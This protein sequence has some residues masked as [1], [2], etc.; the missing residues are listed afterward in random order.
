MSL[1]DARTLCPKLVVV[2]PN[3]PRYLHFS[4]MLR[5]IYSDYTDTVEPFGLDECWL[6]VTG[7]GLLFGSPEKIAHDIRRRVRFELGITVSVGVSWNKI[8]AKLGS[9]YKKPNAVTVI[10]KDNYKKIVYPLPVS[11]LAAFLG[12]MGYILHA[13]ANGRESSPVTASGCAPIIK[14]VGNG[15]TAPRDLKNE[16]DIKSV[17]YVLTE[18][19]ARRLR[20]QG[21]KGRVV[22]IGIR[23]KNL[24]SFTRQSRLKIATND[25]GKLQ[26]AALELFRANYSFDTMPPVRALTVSVSELCDENEA[27]Q[28]D[29]F[30]D[31]ALNEKINRLNHTIDGLK[32]R[33]GSYC[34]RQAFLLSDK[35]LSDFDPYEKNIIHPVS[36]FK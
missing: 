19:V 27:F 17:Q 1:A 35:Q 22:S 24:F 2:P 4:K 34:V 20:E 6:D 8:F 36:Y 16:N 12:K 33:F 14:S 29:M 32:D 28:L 25:T 5:Q 3:Y 11:E 31:N 7:S 10:N 13:F 30:E 26:N 21:L 18:S 23:D 15:I 9:D